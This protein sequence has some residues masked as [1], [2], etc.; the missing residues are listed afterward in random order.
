MMFCF[1]LFLPQKM[2]RFLVFILQLPSFL[3]LNGAWVCAWPGV[4]PGLWLTLWFFPPPGSTALLLT[5]CIQHS[6]P[7]PGRLYLDLILAI[8]ALELICSLTCLLIY[9]GENYY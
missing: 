2:S 7:E 1:P 5:L 3:C 4:S 9:T 6:F 8:L